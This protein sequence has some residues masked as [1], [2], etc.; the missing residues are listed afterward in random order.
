MF[1]E[2]KYNSFLPS[3]SVNQKERRQHFFFCLT[4]TNAG[5]KKV[6]ERVEKIKEEIIK[7][8]VTVGAIENESLKMKTERSIFNT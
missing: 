8:K 1:I 2:N 7:S 4:F 6:W 5:N 3:V